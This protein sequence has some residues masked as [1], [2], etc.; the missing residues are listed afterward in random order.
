MVIVVVADETELEGAEQIVGAAVQDWAPGAGGVAIF[1]AHVSESRGGSVEV[2]AL[3]CTPQGATVIEVKGFTERQAGILATPPNGPWTVDGAP[4]ALYHAVRVPNPFVQV[5]R[6]VFAVKN[7]LQQAGIFGWVNAV[8]AL[9]PQP[10]SQITLEEAR[11]ADGYRA[12]LVDRDDST[13]LR[14]YFHAETGRTMRISVNDVRRVFEALNLTHLLPTRVALADQGFPARLQPSGTG[15]PAE[16]PPIDLGQDEDTDEIPTTGGSRWSGSRLAHASPPA[17][18]AAIDRLTHRPQ[19][20]TGTDSPTTGADSPVREADSPQ[21]DPANTPVTAETAP[22]SDPGTDITDPDTATTPDG[23]DG[24]RAGTVPDDGDQLRPETTPDGDDA[25]GPDAAPAGGEETAS[26]PPTADDDSRTT[27][28]PAGEGERPVGTA[29]ESGTGRVEKALPLDGVGEAGPADST[30]DAGSTPAASPLESIEPDG[31]ADLR[32]E[33]VLDGDE[34]RSADLAPTGDNDFHGA[35]TAAGGGERPADPSPTGGHDLH[36]GTTSADDDEVRTRYSP[37]SG[38]DSR[39]EAAPHGGDEPP[40]DPAPD[41]GTG[42]IEPESGDTVPADLPV[43]AESKPAVSLI[44]S[45]APVDPAR[46]AAEDSAAID[47]RPA[48]DQGPHA[49]PG[50]LRSENAGHGTQPG[51]GGREGSRTESADPAGAVLGSP[52]YDD[53]GQGPWAD[54]GG[55]DEPADHG[56]HGGSGDDHGRYASTGHDDQE[57]SASEN[58]GGSGDDHGHYPSTG[59]SDQGVPGGENRGASG[60]GERREAWADDGDTWADDEEGSSGGSSGG[61]AAVGAAGVAAGALGAAAWSSSSDDPRSSQRS[62]PAP[63]EQF[64]DSEHWSDWVDH[65]RAPVSPVAAGR[66]REPGRRT[67]RGGSLLERWRNTPVRERER[68][69]RAGWLPRIGPGIGLVLFIA[70]FGAV[71][72]TINAVQASRFVMSDYDR[73][74][75]ADRKPFPNAAAYE[76]DGPSPIYL[77]GGLGDMVTERDARAWRPSDPSTVQLIACMSQLELRELVQT[78]Q[79]APAPGEPIG[80]T[81]NLF[82]ASYDVVVYELRTGREVARATMLGDRYSADPANT[83]PDRCRAAADA[84]DVLGRRLG[85]PSA[86]QVTGFLAPVVHPDR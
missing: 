68:S 23:A 15:R 25:L 3:V 55:R 82:R 81:V 75:G 4:A 34:E 84:P 52:G 8:V 38:A 70:L 14:D 17:F 45:T 47:S 37:T 51:N 32:A 19:P 31:A 40:A 10:G 35:T 30:A 16:Q 5:R 36:A 64:D 27:T 13:A 24:L 46:V 12:V 50:S 7:L 73:M 41:D 85:Q 20:P 83:D 62:A 26:R 6:Q 72:F 39:T 29:P 48:D 78:C 58:R 57:A 65:E 43:G 53:A 74:C 76:R 42:V 33:T 80:R 49:V 54:D 59:N 44:K 86:G 56:D 18:L 61:Y 77:S 66:V 21:P 11:I 69:P 1:R 71:F 67:A 22:A 2:D 9:V 28:P 63:G 60:G 79:Y